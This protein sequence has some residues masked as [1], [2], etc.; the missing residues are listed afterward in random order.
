MLSL[1]DKFEYKLLKKINSYQLRSKLRY[2]KFDEN[3]N[4]HVSFDILILP[5]INE[6]SGE[7]LRS[8]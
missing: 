8:L 5:G 1:F 4:D 2:Y 7:S 3:V 6:G